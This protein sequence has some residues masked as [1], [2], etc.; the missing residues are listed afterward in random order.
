MH[1]MLLQQLADNLLDQFVEF[2]TRDRDKIESRIL[3]P[4][5]RYLAER[6]AWCIRVFQA[7][8]VLVLVQT[9]VLLYLLVR[10]Q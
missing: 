4:A 10:R 6:F 5:L 9:I 3:K 2:C 8:A 1:G 7:V